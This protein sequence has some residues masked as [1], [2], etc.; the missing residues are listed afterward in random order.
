MSSLL[1]GSDLKGLTNF[2][3]CFKAATSKISEM[4][5]FF[6]EIIVIMHGSFV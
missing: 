3:K 4:L 6:W 2:I 1:L 5:E